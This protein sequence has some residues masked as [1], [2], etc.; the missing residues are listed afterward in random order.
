MRRIILAGIIVLVAGFIIKIGVAADAVYNKTI[1]ETFTVLDNEVEVTEM[2]RTEI[3]APGWYIPAGTEETIVIN[4]LKGTTDKVQKVIES[5]S[6]TDSEGRTL[7]FFHSTD[8][9]NNIVVS[10]SLPRNIEYGSPYFIQTKYISSLL[11]FK[12]GTLRDLYIPG[13]DAGFQFSAGQYKFSYIAKILVPKS[14]GEINLVSPAS[15]VIDK[16]ELWEI[17]ISGESLVGKTGWVQIGRKQIYEFVISQ[18]YYPTSSIP[19][20]FNTFKT[21]LP[22]SIDNSKTTQQT[23]YTYFSQEPYM[24]EKDGDKNIIATFKVPS[25]AS[26]EII[27]K[28]YSIS[29]NNPDISV[30]NAGT[31]TQIDSKIIEDNT[32]PAQ[33]WE[34]SSVSIKEVAEGIKNSLTEEEKEN[35]IYY[36]T[37]KAYQF[38]IERIDYSLTKKYGLNERKGALATLNG[39]AAVCM[40]YS[41]L[42]IAIMRSLGVPTRAA[43]GYG[44]SAI[45]LETINETTINHQWAEVYFPAI[46]MW[47]PVDT[48]WGEKGDQIIGGDLN[49]FYSHVASIDPNTPNSAEFFFFGFASNLEDRVFTVTPVESVS[50]SDT[51]IESSQL[52]GK[53]PAKDSVQTVLD[54][55]AGGIANTFQT[56]DAALTNFLTSSLANTSLSN[57]VTTVKTAIYSIPVCLLF[58]F[59]I[60]KL[61]RKV[62]KKSVPQLH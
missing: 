58:L 32:K 41:D 23:F 1:E 22:K 53:Y 25:N 30:S 14:F 54:N 38:V 18:K 57:N 56:I 44:Y 59:I 61:F 46:N 26:G 36:L 48:T 19:F 17:L 9:E 16:G 50:S 52:P 15:G 60:L 28:G 39:G 4:S 6:V 5:I 29:E 27:I 55:V 51:Q 47:I 21:V 7:P 33:F 34:S 10:I 13:L 12:T 62:R 45:D 35:E 31:I 24:V 20:T 8:P 42:F 3:L 43:F 2:R 11:F 49:H 40:E 37:V